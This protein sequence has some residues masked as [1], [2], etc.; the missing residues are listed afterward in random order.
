MSS[1]LPEEMVKKI[2]VYGIYLVCLHHTVAVV[3]NDPF[4]FHHIPKVLQGSF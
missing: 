1:E 4:Q 3:V 2:E